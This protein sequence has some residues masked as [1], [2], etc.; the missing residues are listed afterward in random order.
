MAIRQLRFKGDP[1]LRKKSRE[2]TKIDD[3]IKILLEDMLETMY[4]E[5]GVGLAAPQVGI[6]RRVVVIDVGDGP[7][8]LINPEIIEED[9]EKIDEEGCLSVPGESGK[10]KRPAMVKVKY[11]DENGEEQ[12]IEGTGLLARALCHEIDHLNGILFIDK[13]IEADEE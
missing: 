11:L 13:I 6:L 7:I 10:V 1:I 12:I 3:R 8:K 9:G 4:K 5:E 2:V